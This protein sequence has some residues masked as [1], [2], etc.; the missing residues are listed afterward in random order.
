MKL[1]PSSIVVGLCAVCSFPSVADAHAACEF[2]ANVDC[3][4]AA[5]TG[6]PTAAVSGRLQSIGPGEYYGSLEVTT[7]QAGDPTT[8]QTQT[9]RV[10]GRASANSGGFEGR[11]A[12]GDSFTL[13]MSGVAGDESSVRL[14]SNRYVTRC[15]EPFVSGSPTGSDLTQ[16]GYISF[17]PNADRQTYTLKLGVQNSGDA[18]FNFDPNR[19]AVFLRG[20]SVEW[21]V[22]PSRMVAW[23]SGTV[24][25]SIPPH[26]SAVIE[27]KIYGTAFER[28]ATVE[29]TIDPDRVLQTSTVNPFTDDVTTHRTPCLT[30]T[31]RLTDEALGTLDVSNEIASA[32]L[33]DNLRY[34]SIGEFVASWYV[35]RPDGNVC[36]FCHYR[37]TSNPYHPPVERGDIGPVR[38]PSEDFG[39][40]SWD[41]VRD[42]QGLALQFLGANPRKPRYLRLI[43]ERWIRDGMRPGGEGK[44]PGLRE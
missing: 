41:G 44:V 11:A 14:G 20:T 34:M 23:G 18:V 37:N 1:R 16:F 36:S 10:T 42:G 27:S 28:C 2:E 13:Y 21:N 38:N 35:V 33:R 22:G 30:W 8:G 40:R 39:G 32:E 25:T 17:E 12:N 4:F 19:W 29:I 24:L 7:M 15:T 3:D 5:M 6:S 26:D 31:S 43:M 9:I